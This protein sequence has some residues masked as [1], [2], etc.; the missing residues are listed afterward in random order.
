MFAV[1]IAG[2]EVIVACFLSGFGLKARFAA[3][4]LDV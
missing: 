3:I 1:G 2:K 4:F